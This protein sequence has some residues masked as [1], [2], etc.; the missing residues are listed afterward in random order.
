MQRACEEA[1]ATY[2]ACT[3]DQD[4]GEQFMV[5]RRMAIPA[6]ERLGTV[7]IEDVGVPIARIPDLMAGIETLASRHAT[8]IAVIGHAGDGNFHPLIVFDHSDV[9]AVER[10]DALS[11]P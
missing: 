6:V 8:T 10:A 2:V 11:A 9:S 5:A 4:E 7:L 1:G 3:D